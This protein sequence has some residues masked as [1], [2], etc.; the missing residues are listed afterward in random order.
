GRVAG[1]NPPDFEVE[2]SQ[3][4][5]VH[6]PGGK[7]VGRRDGRLK[8]L[9]K[10]HRNTVP[11]VR[12]VG[13]DPGQNRLIVTRGT[14]LGCRGRHYRVDRWEGRA[15]DLRIREESAVEQVEQGDVAVWKAL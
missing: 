8:I 4:A 3:Q 1:R 13:S 14:D 10:D 9:V 5:V 2:A 15:I 12:C 7:R 11:L 6:A